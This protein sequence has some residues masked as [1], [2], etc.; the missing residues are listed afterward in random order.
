MVVLLRPRHPKTLIRREQRPLHFLHCQVCG[1]ENISAA[2]EHL[3]EG[4]EA[5]DKANED[6]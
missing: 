4:Q 6:Y 5:V 3:K 2:N 1:Y